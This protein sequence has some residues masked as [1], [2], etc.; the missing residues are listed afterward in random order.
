MFDPTASTSAGFAVTAG[1][2]SLVRVLGRISA[3]FGVGCAFGCW[4]RVAGW[5]SAFSM[6]GGN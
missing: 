3:G 6:K 5:L 2:A 1:D 4:T